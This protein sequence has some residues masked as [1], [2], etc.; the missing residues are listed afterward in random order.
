MVDG[1]IVAGKYVRLACKRHLADLENGHQRGLQWSVKRSEKVIAFFERFLILAEGDFSDRPFVLQ[2]WQCFV[3]GC[4]FG[5][6]GPDGYRRFRTA[7]I[8]IGKGNGKTPMAAGIGLYGTIADGE[9]AAEVYS[10]AVTKEQAG[11]TF[12]DAENMVLASPGLKNRLRI[13]RNCII[14]RKTNSLFRVISSEKRGLDGK[15]PHIALIDEIHEHP[16][17]TVVD[18]MRAG[19]KGRRQALIF[20]I[21]NSGYDRM[22]VCWD[23][24]EQSIKIL[25]GAYPERFMVRL[26]G[27]AG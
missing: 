8:E 9:K 17:A 5:W 18:K 21:T 7:Y 19:T 2:P 6:L 3:I 26:R 22:T 10:A 27:G 13:L 20:E 15:R 1:K 12:R 11:L 24:H 23:H 16:T 14:D 25:E 4:I